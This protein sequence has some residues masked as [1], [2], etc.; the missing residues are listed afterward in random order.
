MFPGVV[1]GWIAARSDQAAE[2][3]AVSGEPPQQESVLVV[4]VRQDPRCLLIPSWREHRTC[5]P[6]RGPKKCLRSVSTP[7]YQATFVLESC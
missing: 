5:V 4:R 1:A 3:A 7:S 2:Q 6:Q